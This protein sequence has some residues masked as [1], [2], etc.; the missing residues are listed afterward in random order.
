MPNVLLSE[1]VEPCIN[2]AINLV[3]SEYKE[4]TGKN[5]F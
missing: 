5:I 4:E 1:D 2:L 3:D